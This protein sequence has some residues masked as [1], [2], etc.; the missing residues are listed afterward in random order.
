MVLFQSLVAGVA[1]DGWQTVRYP[2][3]GLLAAEL[4][5]AY[6]RVMGERVPGESPRF[7]GRE[8]Q[9]LSR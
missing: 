9:V 8:R 5:G 6:C 3:H 4:D 7:S 2:L 1:T